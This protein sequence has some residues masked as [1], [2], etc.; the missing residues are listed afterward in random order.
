MG[1]FAFVNVMTARPRDQRLV[2]RRALASLAW[3]AVVCYCCLEQLL[4]RSTVSSE[5]WAAPGARSSSRTRLSLLLDRRAV[6]LSLLGVPGQAA[7]AADADADAS[8][9]GLEA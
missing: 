9:K 4:C 3:L 1:F 5:T 2:L 7:V 8:K 6:M